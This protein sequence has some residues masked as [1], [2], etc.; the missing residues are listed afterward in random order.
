MVVKTYSCFRR[1]KPPEQWTFQMSEVAR[2]AIRSI[3][4]VSDRDANTP[5]KNLL[6]SEVHIRY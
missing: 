4:R 5:I 1:S 2:N 6:R 3:R